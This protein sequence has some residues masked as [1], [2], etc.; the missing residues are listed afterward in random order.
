MFRVALI[1]QKGE[2]QPGIGDFVLMSKICV[3]GTKTPHLSD[4]AETSQSET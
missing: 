3:N 1:T 4:V 2:V